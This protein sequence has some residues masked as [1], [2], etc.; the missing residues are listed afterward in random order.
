M[1]QQASVIEKPVREKDPRL[2]DE[3]REEAAHF[4]MNMYESFLQDMNSNSHIK[5]AICDT[6]DAYVST[7]NVKRFT[8]GKVIE[9][10]CP[11]LNAMSISGKNQAAG[12]DPNDINCPYLFSLRCFDKQDRELDYA[13]RM[14]FKKVSKHGGHSRAWRACYG[15]LLKAYSFPEGLYLS[16]NEVLRLEVLNPD[17]NIDRIELSMEADVFET[18]AC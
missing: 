15:D 5:K 4:E 3:L 17:I 12:N 14:N 1:V 11:S 8:S 7:F 16:E 18:R 9:L 10:R 2:I 6:D 13:T